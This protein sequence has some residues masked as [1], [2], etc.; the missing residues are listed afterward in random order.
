[1]SIHDSVAD[2]LTIIRNGVTTEVNLK[3]ISADPRRDIPLQPEDQ[4]IVP[5]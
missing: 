1:M 2:F 3:D 4:I 5:E